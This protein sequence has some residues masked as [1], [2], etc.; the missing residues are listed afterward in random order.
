V[1][2]QTEQQDW[3]VE[4]QQLRYVNAAL[5]TGGI[6][7]SIQYAGN[8]VYVITIMVPAGFDLPTYLDGQR[9]APRRRSW[10]Q[11]LD[12]GRWA[13]VALLL[14]VIG[15]TLYLLAYGAPAALASALPA[16]PAIQWPEI[17]IDIP[18]PMAGIQ[19]QI[20]GLMAGAMMI[21]Q[22]AAGLVV[23]WLLWVFRGPL[24]GIG[25]GIWKAGN[26]AANMAT[27]AAKTKGAK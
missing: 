2:Q 16:M 12:I 17:Q 8:G 23:L 22:L 27:K 10:W 11:R 19:R 26:A 20:D 21:V 3:Q 13:P 1:S 5:Q 14:A 6:Q 15:A 18:N 24:S 25:G 9:G 4:G 7:P